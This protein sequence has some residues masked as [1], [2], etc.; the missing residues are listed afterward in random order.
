MTEQNTNQTEAQPTQQPTQQPIIINNVV[1]SQ[2]DDS[3]KKKAPGFLKV[4]VYSVF[5]GGLYFFYWL[6]KMLSGG[7]SKR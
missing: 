3:G 4:C 7:Y 5:T 6:V 2:H 1:P